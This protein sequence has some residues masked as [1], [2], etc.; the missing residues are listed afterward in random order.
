MGRQMIIFQEQW[1]T[2]GTQH[3][4]FVKL[5]QS[6]STS[7]TRYPPFTIK[8]RSMYTLVPQALKTIFVKEIQTQLPQL[9]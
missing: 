6:T 8:E 4:P 7:V 9:T 1:E 5:T 3:S 2:N